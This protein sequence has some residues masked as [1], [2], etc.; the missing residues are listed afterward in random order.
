VSQR[1]FP[2]EMPMPAADAQTIGF[3]EAAHEH[4]LVVQRCTQCGT[5]RHPPGPRCAS[6]RSAGWEWLELAGTGSL[7]TF[8]IVRQAFIPA[9]A[10]QL[11]YVVGAV[12]LDEGGGVRMVSNIVGCDPADVAIGMALCVIWEDMGPDLALPRFAPT[13]SAVF[14]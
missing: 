4:R 9:L 1:F 7:Y 10:E 2:D 3:W 6:C 13:D 8:S 11:P 12:E 5:T 14:S